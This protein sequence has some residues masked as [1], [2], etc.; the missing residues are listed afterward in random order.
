[1]HSCRIIFLTAIKKNAPN[2][3]SLRSTD[4]RNGGFPAPTGVQTGGVAMRVRFWPELP[5]IP[6]FEGLESRFPPG[7]RTGEGSDSLRAFLEAARKA[8]V[9]AALPGHE[10]RSAEPGRNGCR[11][12]RSRD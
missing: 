9:G 2:P 8:R 4:E 7:T 5:T 10:D 6:D 11:K 12:R 3:V 1:M